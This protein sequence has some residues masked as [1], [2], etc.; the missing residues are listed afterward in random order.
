MTQCPLQTGGD[1]FTMTAREP[2]SKR[3]ASPQ[4][5][6]SPSANSTEN[7]LPKDPGRQGHGPGGAGVTC[8]H[9]PVPRRFRPIVSLPPKWLRQRS[10]PPPE[11]RSQ[12]PSLLARTRS[13]AS[14]LG[15]LKDS[16]A[17]APGFAS[18][19]SGMGGGG[20][21]AGRG[22]SVVLVRRVASLWRS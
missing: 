11:P 20:A 14:G 7:L 12:H 17:R 6:A 5:S 16:V 10:A 8:G 22:R 21:R 15:R 1:R 13:R 2:L 19:A 4:R 3:S 9:S 18:G